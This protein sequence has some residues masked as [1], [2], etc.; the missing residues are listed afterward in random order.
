MAPKKKEEEKRKEK[1]KKCMAVLTIS[2]VLIDGTTLL[3]VL[4]GLPDARE[5]L[6][7]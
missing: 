2:G 7:A 4:P 6:H 5:I 3:V 1:K